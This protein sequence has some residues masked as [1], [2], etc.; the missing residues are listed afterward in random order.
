[1]DPI[2]PERF[3]SRFPDLASSLSAA[4]LDSLLQAFELQDADAGEALV[5]EGTPTGDLFLVWD[6]RLDITM[7]GSGG[8]RRLGQVTA[9]AYFGEVALLDPGQAGVSVVTEQG[10]VVLRLSRERFD[11]LRTSHPETAAPLLEEVVRSL[12]ARLGSAGAELVDLAAG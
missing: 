6:G 2:T 3:S 10:C 1:V 5:A 8:E 7:R 12:A 11:E 9:G 4:E